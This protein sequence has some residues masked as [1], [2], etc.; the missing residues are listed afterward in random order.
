MITVYTRYHLISK[1]SGKYVASNG[2]YAANSVRIIS[3]PWDNSMNKMWELIP[4]NSKYQLRNCC[5]NSSQ[6]NNNNDNDTSD[7]IEYILHR[8]G[9]LGYPDI[10]ANVEGIESNS[11]VELEEENIDN[12]VKIRLVAKNLYL[13]SDANGTLSWSSLSSDS[14]SQSWELSEVINSAR[15]E[16]ANGKY[17][18]YINKYP[19]AIC[20][21]SNSTRINTIR[22]RLNVL[23]SDTN[24]DLD[25]ITP[26]IEDNYGSYV[27]C[28]PRVRR[29][30]GQKTY[31]YHTESN[32]QNYYIGEKLYEDTV[33]DTTLN[34]TTITGILTVTETSRPWYWA[35]VYANRIREAV[36]LNFAAA[37]N[38]EF[39]IRCNPFTMPSNT[40][41]TS[42]TLI[43]APYLSSYGNVCQGSEPG[44]TSTCDCGTG[45]PNTVQNILNTST[46]NNETFH[47]LGLTAAMSEN[48]L[49]SYINKFVKVTSV[50]DPTFSVVVRITDNGGNVSNSYIEVCDRVYRFLGKPGTGTGHVTVELMGG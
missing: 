14:N 40:G 22:D 21:D 42:S 2:Y 17:S 35:L 30:I 3:E 25:F 12:V 13:T 26:S 7:D 32:P 28:C 45:Y 11:E 18:L 37:I 16:Y 43:S 34:S 46:S 24:R 29:N 39:R 9:N 5:P 4:S 15:T 23:F 49:N 38:N 6:A 41:T 44:E 33:F 1:K 19:I 36:Y 48:M 31:L 47:P 20:T 50:S 10:Y 8:H 27:V